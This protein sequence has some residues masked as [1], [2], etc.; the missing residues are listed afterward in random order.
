LL[1]TDQG[2]VTRCAGFIQTRAAASKKFSTA[3]VERAA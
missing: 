3:I 1:F 2:L